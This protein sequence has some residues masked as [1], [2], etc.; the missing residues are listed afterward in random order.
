MKL[1]CRLFD[2]LRDLSAA[3][4]SR[5]EAW[6]QLNGGIESRNWGYVDT[7]ALAERKQSASRPY[8]KPEPAGLANLS[9]D[10]KPC[11]QPQKASS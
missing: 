7:L 8:L 3:R 9:T 5:H 2:L 10:G 6:L 1:L 4:C 11:I